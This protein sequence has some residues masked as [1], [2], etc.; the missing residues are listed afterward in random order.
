M[1]SLANW[2]ASGW[3]CKEAPWL[4]VKF[5]NFLSLRATRLRRL[6]AYAG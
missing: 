6:K 1:T 4:A 5:T 2:G 3:S